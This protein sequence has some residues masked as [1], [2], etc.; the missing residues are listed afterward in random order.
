MYQRESMFFINQYSSKDR[1]GGKNN[2]TSPGLQWNSLLE[3][4]GAA[5]RAEIVVRWELGQVPTVLETCF[6]KPCGICTMQAVNLGP[7]H[8]SRS[9]IKNKNQNQKPKNKNNNNKKKKLKKI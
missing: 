3:K 7:A 2:K 4:D 6:H 8:I 1:E 5:K 9:Q